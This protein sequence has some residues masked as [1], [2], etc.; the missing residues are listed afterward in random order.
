[1]PVSIDNFRVS[2][3]P[4]IYAIGQVDKLVTVHSQ[5]TRAIALAHLL[6]R[7]VEASERKNLCVIGAGIAGLTVSLALLKL[8]WSEITVLERLPD[9]LGV[10]NGCDT[11]WIHPH[12]I[13]WP[14]AGSETPSS[15]LGLLDWTAS[16]AS[17]VAFQIEQ[18]WIS[19]VGKLTKDDE[20]VGRGR[21][22]RL[23]SVN[24]GVTY[25]RAIASSKDVRIEW[26]R[27]A[28]V[29]PIGFRGSKTDDSGAMFP[30]HIILAT[31]YGV[32]PSAK[33][34][35]WRNESY[36][37]ARID[38]IQ[39]QFMISGL[40]DGAVSDLCRLTIRN[41]RTDRE[42]SRL[43]SLTQLKPQLAKIKLTSPNA[44]T[45]L[46]ERFENELGRSGEPKKHW[47]NL[48]SVLSARRREDTKV[49]VYKRGK[50]GFQRAFDL[51]PASF[52][53]KLFLYA[54]YKI[55]GFQYVDGAVYNELEDAT[56][57]FSI[58]EEN[59]IRRTGVDRS[60]MISKVLDFSGWP[61]IDNKQRAVIVADQPYKECLKVVEDNR[62][63]LTPIP[64]P[65]ATS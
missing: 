5:Q 6:T 36:G 56:K 60:K 24:V 53:N 13:D 62:L 47:K 27:D 61:E 55:G 58:P 2:G 17:N 34:S 29:R 7:Q 38:G 49:F 9:L 25:V 10:Q 45:S 12:L 11:R 35:Y 19:E 32:E 59:V 40:G 23:L 48:L 1:M 44:G 21:P 51:S 43:H 57:A 46:F 18:E 63:L 4:C 26:L 64:I 30:S 20:R 3:H 50:D 42:I 16:T 8:G 52:L 65:A 54:L 41:F 15:N 28:R 33:D 31:G 14:D 37:Q 22:T 39:R